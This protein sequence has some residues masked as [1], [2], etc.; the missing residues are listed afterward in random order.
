MRIS[1]IWCGHS[2]PLRNIIPFYKYELLA[3]VSFYWFRHWEKCFYINIFLDIY[4]GNNAFSHRHSLLFVRKKGK[5]H[6]TC[7]VALC[8]L[9][10]S[11]CCFVFHFPFLND[12]LVHFSLC[13]CFCAGHLSS[14]FRNNWR[15]LSDDKENNNTEKGTTPLQNNRNNPFGSDFHYPFLC[16]RSFFL[17]YIDYRNHSLFGIYGR[18]PTI[19]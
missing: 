6:S 5:K 10:C 17:F 16:H 4:I 19:F 18:K 7:M 1:M 3:H 13:F 15:N 9:Q 2:V 14:Y 12:L 8:H 11:R